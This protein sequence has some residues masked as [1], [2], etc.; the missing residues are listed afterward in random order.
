MYSRTS[1][2]H[3]ST[4]IWPKRAQ[5]DGWRRRRSMASLVQLRPARAAT[6]NTLIARSL[7]CHRANQMV[8]KPP[9]PIGLPIVSV[10][11]S[12]ASRCV[13]S[14]ER[15]LRRSCRRAAVRLTPSCSWAHFC[16]VAVARGKQ[17]Q[18]KAPPLVQHWRGRTDTSC[19]MITAGAA[20]T[21]LAAASS[22]GGVGGACEHGLILA[23]FPP[24]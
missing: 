10:D 3:S 19:T 20:A 7:P 12:T 1:A 21:R 11:K 13:A 18:T 6:L 8:A 16:A 15:T 2:G 22:A 24:V 4:H 23:F 14:S 9:L 5:M 17:P